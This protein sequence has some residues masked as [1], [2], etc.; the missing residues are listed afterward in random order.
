MRWISLGLSVFALGFACYS[1]WYAFY[2]NKILARKNI[3]LLGENA[4]LREKIEDYEGEI[5]RLRNMLN[6]MEQN[7]NEN[8]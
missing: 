6:R 1:A 2:V 7:E 5:F 3:N 8:V 4:R